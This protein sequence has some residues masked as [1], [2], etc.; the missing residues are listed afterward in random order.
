VTEGSSETAICVSGS[1]LSAIVILAGAKI[2]FVLISKTGSKTSFP[3][4][5]GGS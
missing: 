2:S 3:F 5:L 4:H 1:S